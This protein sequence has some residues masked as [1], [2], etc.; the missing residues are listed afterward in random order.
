MNK[1]KIIFVRHG[2][3]DQNLDMRAGKQIKEYDYPL[4][5]TGINEAQATR[6]RLATTHIDVIIASSMLRA[7]M[8]AEIINETHHV[9]II[10]K[11]DLRERVAGG[12]DQAGWHELFD[13]DKNIKPEGDGTETAKDFF[14]R[15]YAVIDEI[16][17]ENPNKTI[18]VVAHGGV[19][20]AF[21][22]YFNKLPLEGNM[23]IDRVHN[24]D[25]RYYD[26][27]EDK[28]GDS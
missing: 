14:E 13:M 24:A 22:A 28:G 11:N 10:V 20:H 25:I 21:H 18:A 19:H 1:L 23:R 9:P 7:K 12:V 16:I 2:Q 8:T 5:E 26:L 4:N 6:D 15:V 17:V 27:S 3:T